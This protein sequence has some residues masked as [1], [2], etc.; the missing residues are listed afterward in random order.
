[1]IGGIIVPVMKLQL[2]HRRHYATLII[3]ADGILNWLR[4]FAGEVQHYCVRRW[5]GIKIPGLRTLREQCECGQWQVKKLIFIVTLLPGG[6]WGDAQCTC[7]GNPLGKG[8]VWKCHCS[9]S[10]RRDCR[11]D[12]RRANRD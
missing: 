4:D 5:Q 1:M 11:Q 6:L 3:P 12:A 7:R 10:C 9:I 8:M 2:S